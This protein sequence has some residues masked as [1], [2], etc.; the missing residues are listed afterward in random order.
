MVLAWALI[1]RISS[2][3]FKIQVSNLPTT[4]YSFRIKKG[5]YWF[6]LISRIICVMNSQ[7]VYYR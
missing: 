3:K 5:S 7:R 2:F 1:L 6:F 4:A